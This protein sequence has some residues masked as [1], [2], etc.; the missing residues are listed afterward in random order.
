MQE[1][2]DYWKC[3]PCKE[4]VKQGKSLIEECGHG[5]ISG[6]LRYR[7]ME[8]KYRPIKNLIRRFKNAIYAFKEDDV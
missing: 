4:L 8:M 1:Y 3:D 6:I 7:H 2:P 5:S